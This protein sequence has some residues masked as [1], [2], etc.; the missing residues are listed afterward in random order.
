MSRPTKRKAGERKSISSVLI[1][2]IPIESVRL[3][4]HYKKTPRLLYVAGEL[5]RAAHPA[6]V[7]SGK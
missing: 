5:C 7:H 3:R 6:G 1:V 2:K 4:W